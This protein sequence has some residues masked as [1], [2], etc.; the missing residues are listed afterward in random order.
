MK[1]LSQ[2]MIG[3]DLRGPQI[4]RARRRL[5]REMQRPALSAEQRERLNHYLENLG[6]PKV[7]SF[8]EPPK[9]GALDPGP[10]PQPAVEIDVGTAT[11]DSISS[12]PHTRLYM[13]ARQHGLQVNPGDTKAQIVKAILADIQGENP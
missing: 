1:H 2:Q 6:K 12:L 11:Y 4:Q 10:M 3:M 9:P 13:Y 7:Y 8:D 5:Q